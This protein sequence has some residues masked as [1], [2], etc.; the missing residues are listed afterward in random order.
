MPPKGNSKLNAG[1]IQHQ[2]TPLMDGVAKRTLSFAVLSFA[3]AWKVERCISN[4]DQFQIYAIGF[5]GICLLINIS[6]ALAVVIFDIPKL[7]KPVRLFVI[8][9]AICTFDI[10]AITQLANWNVYQTDLGYKG[11]FFNFGRKDSFLHEAKGI[12]INEDIELNLKD[13]DTQKTVSSGEG[14]LAQISSDDELALFYNKLLGSHLVNVLPETDVTFQSQDITCL[15]EENQEVTVLFSIKGTPPW[16]VTYESYS[17]DGRYSQNELIISGS[18]AIDTGKGKFV[19]DIPLRVQTPGA[20]R[21]ISVTEVID[22]NVIRAGSNFI[23]VVRCPT[24]KVIE[25]KN[26]TSGCI[27]EKKS[28]ALEVVGIPPFTVWYQDVVH[29]NKDLR[30]IQ[31]DEDIKLLQRAPTGFVKSSDAELIDA[32]EKTVHDSLS[33]S[34]KKTIDFDLSEA[35][36]YE[37]SILGVQ[38]GRNNTVIFSENVYR[39]VF[40]SLNDVPSKV[41]SFKQP[42]KFWIESYEFP[43]A[44]VQSCKD[45]YIRTG[46]KDSQEK[47]D[48]RLYGSPPFVVEYSISYL[49]NNEELVKT[50]HKAEFGTNLASLIVNK[51]GKYI[52]EAVYDSQCRTRYGKSPKNDHSGVR[53]NIHDNEKFIDTN[54]ILSTD[55]SCDVFAANAPTLKVRNSRSLEEECSTVGIE[56]ALEFT[57]HPPFHITYVVHHNKKRNGGQS[58]GFIAEFN[59]VVGIL[60]YAPPYDGEYQIEITEVSDHFYKS[61]PV[62][63][64]TETFTIHPAPNVRVSAVNRV[65]CL[66]S[67]AEAEINLTGEGPWTVEYSIFY[68]SK[69]TDEKFKVQ[70][71]DPN[72]KITI[73]VSMAVVG[74]I[75]IQVLSVKDRK[76]CSR[77]IN[78]QRTVFEVLSSLPYAQFGINHISFLHDT[79]FELPVQVTNAIGK[80]EVS[81]LAPD[82]K[83]Y[84]QGGI[85]NFNFRFSQPG[86]YKLV[87]VRDKYCAASLQDSGSVLRAE[88]IPRPT[89]R[90]D[91]KD[92]KLQ[93][94]EEIK[95]V[96]IRQPVCEGTDDYLKIGMTGKPPFTL[97]Y[98]HELFLPGKDKSREQKIFAE[99]STSL[100]GRLRM[101]TGTA[102]QHVYKFTSITDQNYKNHDVR[103]GIVAV[104]QNNADFKSGRDESIVKVIQEVYARP[105]ARFDSE[106][107]IILQCIS[108]GQDTLLHMELQ[109]LPPFKVQ[110]TKWAVG[111]PA[112]NEILEI[113]SH[114]YFY[115]PG[116]V[117]DLGKY[118]F[119]IVSISDSTG[120]E[121]VY[122]GS[123][124]DINAA[125]DV[126]DM[127]RIKFMDSKSSSFDFED[128]NGDNSIAPKS[129]ICEYDLISYQLKGTPPFEV[130][131]TKG[132]KVYRIGANEQQLEIVAKS[133][134]T[135]NVTQVCNHFGC[136]WKP[137]GGLVTEVKPLP[138][139]LVNHGKNVVVDIREGGHSG[140]RVELIGEPPFEFQYTRTLFSWDGKLTARPPVTGEYREVNTTTYVNNVTDHQYTVTT[141]VD[142]LYRINYVRDAFCQTP[143]H[144]A[145]FNQR[146]ANAIIP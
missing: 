80:A 48:I 72:V 52:I 40:S 91:N 77:N 61:L 67:A 60:H 64:S 34:G 143:N 130:T 142:G 128:D 12:D 31:I 135:V 129:H 9:V 8:F 51:P 28:F 103:N 118:R 46:N 99:Q 58:Q 18:D 133:A 120:C 140:M 13:L 115:K 96:K 3:Y 24:V 85:N 54:G 65:V 42:E 113:D 25:P 16:T 47:F 19:Q 71:D 138:G 36:T 14:T 70:F 32:I 136:C 109:G 66:G 5:L 2:S 111:K 50:H 35:G 20:Y 38:D 55:L 15:S 101:K 37:I 98:T 53:S 21:I 44:R 121:T 84:S 102:G 116:N 45:V 117:V 92:E 97:R 62:S 134:G 88:V 29:S 132:G 68:S 100:N 127:A 1:A 122:V 124:P 119:R 26:S 82:G 108:S 27:H 87:Y 22:S 33:Y 74:D 10:I 49:N 73:P 141:T 139:I 146:A 17:F 76:G 145:V 123:E 23:T 39:D 95:G 114:D 112:E 75:A 56:I 78:D 106:K 90:L 104:G 79:G 110:I 107:D 57:G 6:W 86:E 83:I 41:I 30:A 59:D 105:K 125:V 69:G 94:D 137:R 144:R 89:F 11:G 81:I 126:T 43:S 63:I 93:N 7:K 4:F 131:L